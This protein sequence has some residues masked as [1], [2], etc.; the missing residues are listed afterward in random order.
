M[1]QN[2]KKTSETNTI[3]KKTR[4]QEIKFLVLADLE[5]FKTKDIIEELNELKRRHFD[6]VFILGNIPDTL[7]LEISTLFESSLICQLAEDYYSPILFQELGV[8]DFNLKKQK[9]S[10]A[11]VCGVGSSFYNL[12][13]RNLEAIDN[14]NFKGNI[15]VSYYPPLFN[16]YSFEEHGNKHIKT[17]SK[18]INKFIK[19]K[20][21][22]LIIFRG[23]KRKFEKKLKNGTKLYCCH[24]IQVI[25]TTIEVEI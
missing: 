3:H 17:I 1:Q 4:L 21:P 6:I 24:G 8:V 23:N 10:T 2:N 7:T 5:D 15:L 14:P 18:H 13:T 16:E 22:S 25:Q 9:L 20:Q 11:H 19:E 12:K